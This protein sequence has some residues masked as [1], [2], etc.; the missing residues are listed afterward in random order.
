MNNYFFV[1]SASSC[2]GHYI[3]VFPG[4]HMIESFNYIANH[5]MSSLT[6][7]EGKWDGLGEF[8]APQNLKLVTTKEEHIKVLRSR[9]K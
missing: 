4:D 3:A 5:P 2:G 6:L 9:H 1:Q 7:Y 8:P